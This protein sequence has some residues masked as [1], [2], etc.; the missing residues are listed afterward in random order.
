M[1][2]LGIVSIAFVSIMGLLVVA[3]KNERQASDD[4]A[5]GPMTQYVA[6][7][8]RAQ[9]FASPTNAPTS[10]AFDI[11]GRC[12]ASGSGPLATLPA[13]AFFT[14]NVTA[15]PGASGTFRSYSLSFVWPA[16]ANLSTNSMTLTVA[17]GD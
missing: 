2:A 8:L 6:S 9:P 17:N 1:L 4:T 13:E 16:P 3:L 5:L 11:D 7:T 12:L 14:C 15:L 10:F